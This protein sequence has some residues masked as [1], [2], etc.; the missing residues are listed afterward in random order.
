MPP[1]ANKAISANA[2]P[3]RDM[4]LRKCVISFCLCLRIGLVPERVHDHRGGDEERGKQG[5]AEVAP[6][7][8]Q[9]HQ[10][11]D[12]DEHA[13]AEHDE[14]RGGYAL[15]LG[16]G[17]HRRGL[18]EVTEPGAQEHQ[19]EQDPPDQGYDVHD[20]LPEAGCTTWQPDTSPSLNYPHRR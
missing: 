19:R 16:I 11:T 7:S 1:A 8:E 20:D 12:D 9:D 3:A 5:C 14:L 6:H 18:G 15:A 13:A 2:A 4:S 10:P 17:C